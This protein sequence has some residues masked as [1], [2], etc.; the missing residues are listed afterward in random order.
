MPDVN[1]LIAKIKDKDDKVR[2]AAWVGAG[3]FG[4]GAVKPLADVMEDP[5]AEVR[6]AA[7]NALYTIVRRAGRPGAD[8]ERKAVEAELCG[9]LGP[10][11]PSAVRRELLWMLSE[12]GGDDA[13]LA[14]RRIPG[15]RETRDLWEDVRC[16]IQRIGGDA[17]VAALKKALETAPEDYRPALAS[18]LRALGTEVPG[19]PDHKLVPTKPTSVKP[20]ALR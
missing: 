9:L 6:R 19:V 14:M 12:I 3:D 18:S 13:V 17:A 4:A 8:A 15:L 10:E 20:I 2:C 11:R 5:D 16:T 7:K 1:E